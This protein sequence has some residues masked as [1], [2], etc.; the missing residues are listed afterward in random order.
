M[1]ARY[2]TY[3]VTSLTSACFYV[4]VP[5]QV[6]RLIGLKRLSLACEAAV[7]LQDW[8]LVARGVWR[9]YHLL[10]PLL[11][12][13]AM[14]HLLFQAR[15]GVVLIN[16][17]CIFVMRCCSCCCFLVIRHVR[18]L[19]AVVLRCDV[20]AAVFFWSWTFLNAAGLA[21]FRS[22]CQLLFHWETLHK[23]PQHLKPTSYFFY[24]WQTISPEIAQGLLNIYFA[25]NA[26]F[27]LS[28]ERLHCIAQIRARSLR[29]T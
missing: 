25:A 22:K 6:C 9:A 24:P 8:D 15:S 13:S 1:V 5:A 20:A 12:V 2:L 17:L 18:V 29:C 10:L 3:E 11:R 23:R 7:L 16:S 4:F 28:A 14:G 27:N 26:M 21:G 19:L